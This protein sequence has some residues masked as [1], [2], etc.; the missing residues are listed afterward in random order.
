MVDVRE[1]ILVR[2][3]QLNAEQY[4][5]GVDRESDASPFLDEVLSGV[6]RR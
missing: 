4:A 1:V 3:T 6:L 2:H 5:V